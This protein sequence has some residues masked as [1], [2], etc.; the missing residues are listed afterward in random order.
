MLNPRGPD[1]DH[2]RRMSVA[3][4]A[5]LLGS[6]RGFLAP[7]GV[8]SVRSHVVVVVAARPDGRRGRGPAV[9]RSLP[10]R[11]RGGHR[12]SGTSR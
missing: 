1:N 10:G 7:P 6:R 4:Q 2:L 11:P 5:A 12:A 8:G 9:A 3:Q